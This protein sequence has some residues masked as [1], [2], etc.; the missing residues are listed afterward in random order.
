MKSVLYFI[1]PM[2]LFF[3]LSCNDHHDV[4]DRWGNLYFDVEKKPNLML[5]RKVIPTAFL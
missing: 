3:I 4:R 5:I 1:S 2:V